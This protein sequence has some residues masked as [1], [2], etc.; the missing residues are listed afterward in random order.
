[1]LNKVMLI[2]HLGQAP[3]LDRTQSGTRVAQLSL[4][5]SKR[6]TA[7]GEKKERTEWHRIVVWNEKL[8]DVVE[9]YLEKGSKIYVEGELGTRKWADKDGVTHY[10]TEIL[11]QNFGGVIVML[12][13]ATGGGVPAATGPDDYGHAQSKSDASAGG[14]SP[15]ELDD[16]I[17]F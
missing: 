13:K 3:K 16:E 6:W 15:V 14:R 8:I 17:P 9:K 4:A 7:N 12:D 5:T 1:M 2:G 10:T 11:L